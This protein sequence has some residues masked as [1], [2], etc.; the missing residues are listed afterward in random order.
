MQATVQLLTPRG[1]GA[2]AVIQVRAVD[3]AQSHALLSAFSAEPPRD[4]SQTPINRILFGRWRGEDVVV[5]KTESAVWEIH[6]HGG[7]VAIDRILKDLTDAGASTTETSKTGDADLSESDVQRFLESIICQCRTRRT[8]GV[9]MAQSDGRLMR[10]WRDLHS[11]DLARQTQARL[12]LGTW[13]SVA[14]HLVKPWLIALVGA[15]NAGKSSLMNA[16]AGRN[17]AIVSDVPGTTR[18]LLEADVFLDG[19]PFTFVDSAG[20]RNA[21]ASDLEQSGIELSRALASAADVVCIVVDSS[22]P[23]DFSSLLPND[24]GANVC[25]LLNKIDLRNEQSTAQIPDTML[26][27]VCF[28]AS[29]GRQSPDLFA[30]VS[31]GDS[32]PPVA[33]NLIS[34]R[35]KISLPRFDVSAV[36]G[37][38][39][40][41]FLSW[42]VQFVIPE[43]PGHDTTLPIFPREC[44]DRWLQN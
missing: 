39:L 14:E 40:P 41:Q 38:G 32:H 34:H 16:I 36:T 12:I 5:V 26:R 9:A 31:S 8:A 4:L 30:A 11:E 42:L 24:P 13:R 20:I 18:D 23:G 35:V 37:E 15:P 7:A 22:D 25:L 28:E 43:E 1:A 2:V 6:C 21:A 44:L 10:L 3:E 17:R 29:G 27:S 19:W 33:G